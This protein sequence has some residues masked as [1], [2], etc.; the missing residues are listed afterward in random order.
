MG[1]ADIN[2]RFFNLKPQLSGSGMASYK[3][4]VRR[5]MVEQEIDA[6]MGD[7]KKYN[8]LL[9]FADDMGLLEDN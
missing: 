9:K 1:F 3:A 5:K 6:L 8:Q 2:I 7:I 4:F